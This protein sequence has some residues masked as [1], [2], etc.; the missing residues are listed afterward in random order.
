MLVLFLCIGHRT[1]DEHII[2]L[3]AHYFYFDI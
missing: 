2:K 1:I 3:F